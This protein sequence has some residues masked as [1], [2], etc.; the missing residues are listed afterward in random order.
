M[1]QDEKS[2]VVQSAVHVFDGCCCYILTKRRVVVVRSEND[3][4]PPGVLRHRCEHQKKQ[5]FSSQAHQSKPPDLNSC[6]SKIRAPFI[7][8]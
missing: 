3:T 8:P 5:I 7:N 6:K 1:T 2:V 4:I